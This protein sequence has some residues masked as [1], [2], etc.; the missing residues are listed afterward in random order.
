MTYDDRKLPRGNVNDYYNTPW[1][2]VFWVDVPSST[3]GLH[4]WMPVPLPQVRR[5]QALATPAPLAAVRQQQPAS[6]GR[7]ADPP[8]SSAAVSPARPRPGTL[9]INK[10]HNGQLAKLRVGHVL[11]IR[12]PGNPAT[13]YHW[14]AAPSNTAALRLTVRPQYSPGASAS[15]QPATQGTYTF[16][17]QAVQPGG[18]SI[19][20]Y[21]VRPQDPSHPRDYFAVG[22]KVWP[23]A[24]VSAQPAAFGASPG[25]R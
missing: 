3:W 4:G 25:S 18:G 7:A 21:Y 1:G 17:F 5:G 22:I 24:A 10:S 20:L 13:G 6:A 15:A 23:T 8:A 14:V 12:L 2:P 19:R 11:V 9:E 16:T